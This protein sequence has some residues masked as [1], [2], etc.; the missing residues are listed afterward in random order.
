MGSVL[1][2]TGIMSF[3]LFFSIYVYIIAAVVPVL[4]AAGVISN[5]LSKQ[6]FRLHARI[7][8]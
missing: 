7:I 8:F 2:V 6:E 5:E 1:D 4:L 3:D